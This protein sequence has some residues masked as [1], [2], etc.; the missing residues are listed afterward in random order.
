MNKKEDWE[1]ERDYDQIADEMDKII[2]SI[3]DKHDAIADSVA[4]MFMAAMSSINQV[5]L[6]N[7][8]DPSTVIIVDDHV[9]FTYVSDVDASP[10]K[11]TIRAE[12]EWQLTRA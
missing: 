2:R 1:R 8:I 9:S 3:E 6:L 10:I 4:M 11:I 7:K 12:R 5:H